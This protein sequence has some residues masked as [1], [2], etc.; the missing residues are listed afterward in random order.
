MR[1][2]VSQ[3]QI[4]RR[5]AGS[6]IVERAVERKVESHGCVHTTERSRFPFR[7]DVPLGLSDVVVD[8]RR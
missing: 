5:P 1:I 2:K 7:C 3:R 6:R 4:K 8:A